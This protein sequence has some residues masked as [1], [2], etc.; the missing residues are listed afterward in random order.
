[1]SKRLGKNHVFVY[2]VHDVPNAE[3]LD[4]LAV[5]LRAIGY[6]LS[7][8]KGTDSAKDINRLLIEVKGKPEER[9]IATTTIRSM[10][11]AVYTT[12]NIGH[13]G[14]AFQDY[15]HFTSPIRRYPDVMVHRALEMVLSGKKI[16]LSQSEEERKAVHASEREVGAAEAERASIKLKQVEYFG[17]LIGAERDG[18]I[19]GVTEWGVYIEDK[20]T[21]TEGMARLASMTD[22]SYEFHPKKYAAVG[23]K[24]KKVI[25][26]GDPV[27]YRVE[28]ANL[29][30]RMLDFSVITE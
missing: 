28:R 6:Q 7:I 29:E 17:S 23:S 2:R 1:M 30:E 3:K 27:R 4:E 18:V 22:D 12:K 14:L 20:E 10:A 15:A 11:K 13:F 25:R 21:G 5:F 24:T 16:T 9:L 26:L 19:S 8:G